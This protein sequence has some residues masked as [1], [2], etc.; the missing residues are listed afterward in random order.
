MKR[1]VKSNSH[2]GSEKK[3]YGIYSDKLDGIW[4]KIVEKMM[5]EFSETAH[6]IFR[7][8]SALER[9]RIM[10]QSREQEDCPFQRL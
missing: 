7:A 3:L 1:N 9:R 4:G 10:K 5:I 8:S 2:G 6:P